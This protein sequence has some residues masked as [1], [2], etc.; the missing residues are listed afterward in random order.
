M[1]S[2]TNDGKVSIAG[3]VTMAGGA[4]V[5]GRDVSV[6]GAT[7]DTLNG[8]FTGQSTAIRNLQQGVSNLFE[9]LGLA[10]RAPGALGFAWDNFDTTELLSTAATTVNAAGQ[11]GTSIIVASS[12]AF[13]IGQV[14]AVWS[15]TNYEEVSIS[16]IPDSTHLTL[17]GPGLSNTYGVGD[18]VQRLSGVLPITAGSLASDSIGLSGVFLGESNSRAATTIIATTGTPNTAAGSRLVARD[19]N[20]NLWAVY[21]KTVGGAN[22]EVYLTKSTDQGATWAVQGTLRE[23]TA[24]GINNDPSLAIDVNGS[25]HVVWIDPTTFKVHYDVW[26]G[27]AWTGPAQIDA[28]FGATAKS[29][30]IE[31]DPS[32]VLH[33]VVLDT[34]AQ[35]LKYSKK[36]GAGAWSAWELVQNDGNDSNFS[37]CVDADG[38]PHVMYSIATSA[39]Y[40][41]RRTGGAW[42]TGAAVESNA[43]AQPSSLICDVSGTLH[44]VYLKASPG[45]PTA[46]QFTYRRRNAATGVWSMAEIVPDLPTTPTWPWACTIIGSGDV[47]LGPTGSANIAVRQAGGG[48][49]TGV[50]GSVTTG[51]TL[52]AFAYSLL[53]AEFV[54]GGLY[55]VTTAGAGNII[56]H[57]MS[58]RGLAA[59]SGTQ[60][61]AQAVTIPYV[62]QQKMARVRL[63]L[64]RGNP[65]KKRLS[66][67]AASGQAVMT[68]TAGDTANYAAG[69]TVIV[70][71][72]DGETREKMTILSKT[73]TSI[74]LTANLANTYPTA[75]LV[76][77]LDVTPS[78]S[79]VAGGG[80]ESMAAMTYVDSLSPES[81]W[82]EDEYLYTPGTP[83][84]QVTLKLAMTS[85]HRDIIPAVSAYGLAGEP[86]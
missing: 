1:F 31:I 58:A 85:N 45:M 24:D 13:A 62:F 86:Q 17:T 27:S 3:D 28:A 6:D 15:T 21:T 7:L 76:E 61:K 46:N 77:R 8:S 29:P 64:K 65:L 14:I 37:F 57:S 12:A 82:S 16:A 84:N 4:K 79:V 71:S 30:I 41:T 51:T 19:S 68:F 36:V 22:P 42:T 67:Q 39:L 47:V 54:S 48:W 38:T 59:S 9:Q 75:S 33:V 63:W 53:T 35:R 32:N 50:W 78:M 11:T 40:Y 18:K 81:T 69:D 20:G 60:K 34:S 43:A 74:T 52:S 83:N 49:S 55:Y 56:Y 5:D 2:V 70:R 66:A 80:T 44:L 25:V 23:G 72:T 26:N 10:Q 73:G